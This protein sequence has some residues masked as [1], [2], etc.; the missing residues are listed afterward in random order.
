MLPRPDA[1]PI[2]ES[3]HPNRA[4]Q[5]GY[6]NLVGGQLSFRAGSDKPDRRKAA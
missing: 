3:Y 1:P 4:G 2:G 6:A 5:V